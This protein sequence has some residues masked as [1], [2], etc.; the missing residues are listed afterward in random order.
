VESSFKAE[1]GVVDEA[2]NRLADEC[3]PVTIAI[4]AREPNMFKGRPLGYV[5]RESDE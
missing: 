2:D 1:R 5:R 3:R 4:E